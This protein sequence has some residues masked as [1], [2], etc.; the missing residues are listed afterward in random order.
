MSILTTVTTMWTGTAQAQTKYDLY[1]AGTQVTSDNCNDLSKIKGVTGKVKYD[2]ATKTLLTKII[3]A[4][5][6]AST[7]KPTV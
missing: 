2:N 5:E 7:T 1:I 3:T 4:V 6:S